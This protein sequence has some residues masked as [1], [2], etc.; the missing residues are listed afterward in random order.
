MTQSLPRYSKE[1]DLIDLNRV[2]IITEDNCKKNFYISVEEFTRRLADRYCSN[3][4][5]QP[6][7]HFVKVNFTSHGDYALLGVCSKECETQ[8]IKKYK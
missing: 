3:C 7:I 5:G 8:I 1:S 2:E 6:C 4:K